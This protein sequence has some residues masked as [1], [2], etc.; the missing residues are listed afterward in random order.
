[1][2]YLMHELTLHY[3]LNFQANVTTFRG[4]LAEKPPKSS[5]KRQFLLGHTHLKKSNLGTKN[6]ISMK[7]ARYMYHLNTFHL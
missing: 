5:L 1:M 4:V 7:L 2:A 6:L 3:W